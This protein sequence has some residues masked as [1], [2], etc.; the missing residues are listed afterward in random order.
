MNREEASRVCDELHEYVHQGPGGNPADLGMALG[1]V[2]MLRAAASWD[3]PLAILLEVEVQLARWF[4]PAEWGGSDEGLHCRETVLDH[5]TR[6]EDPCQGP[7]TKAWRNPI[8]D[9][10]ERISGSHQ[11][12]LGYSERDA[13]RGQA[14]HTGTRCS[15]YRDAVTSRSAANQSSHSWPGA[16]LRCCALK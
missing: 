10:P 4:S 1:T 16:K 9:A 14:A 12:R 7:C 11:R 13:S 2:R 15:C 6:L 3:D 8:P 5:V